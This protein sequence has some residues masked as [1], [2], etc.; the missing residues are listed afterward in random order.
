MPYI[1]MLCEAIVSIHTRAGHRRMNLCTCIGRSASG[2]AV[3]ACV[4]AR[5]GRLRGRTVNA[6]AE[7]SA[8]LR[9]RQAAWLLA[10]I[11]YVRSCYTSCSEGCFQ[12]CKVGCLQLCWWVLVAPA[13]CDTS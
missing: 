13:G 1:V 9:D 8:P 12:V 2:T 6:T 3:T 7:L 11:L 5:T 10:C 4:L